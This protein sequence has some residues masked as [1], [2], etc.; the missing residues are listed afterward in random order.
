[1]RRRKIAKTD[2]DGAIEELALGADQRTLA[3]WAAD[4]AVRVLPHFEEV[5][6]D[7]TRPRDAITAL[8]T[9]IKTGVFHM[10]EVRKVSLAAHAAARSVEE[11]DSARSAARAAGQALATAH[12]PRHAFAAALYAATAVRDSAPLED[13]E[14]AALGEREWQYRHLQDLIEGQIPG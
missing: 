2:L 6:P 12:V 14:T 3:T 4:C 11:N 9:W 7:D 1:M 5:S 13:A 10:A 8:R